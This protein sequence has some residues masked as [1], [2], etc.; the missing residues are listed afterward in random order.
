MSTLTEIEAAADALSLKEQKVLLAHL[1]RQIEK[2]MTSAQVGGEFSIKLSKRGFP[3][4]KGSRV[5]TP[6][7]VARIEAEADDAL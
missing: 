7:D 1:A 3:I 5:I 2:S 6:E 4:S